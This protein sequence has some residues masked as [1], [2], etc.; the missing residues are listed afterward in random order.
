MVNTP[1]LIAHYMFRR[2]A[3][4]PAGDGIAR[5]INGYLENVPNV[6][7]KPHPRFTIDHA[8]CAR[9]ARDGAP[10]YGSHIFINRTLSCIGDD[11]VGCAFDFLIDVH[12]EYFAISLRAYPLVTEVAQK[13]G[14]ELSGPHLDVLRIIDDLYLKQHTGRLEEEFGS[15]NDAEERKHFDSRRTDSDIDAVFVRF[16][17]AFFEEKGFVS[18]IEHFSGVDGIG[19]AATFKG[20]VLRDQPLEVQKQSYHQKLDHGALD[21]NVISSE[22]QVSV[23]NDPDSRHRV[24][25]F[26]EINAGAYLARKPHARAA[27]WLAK[28]VN[29]RAIF[30]SRMLGFRL[31]S[32]WIE[33][34]RGGG[35]VLCQMLD[36]LALYGSAMGNRDAGGIEYGSKEVRYF[37]IYAGPSRN[38]L[39]RLIRRIHLCGENR[40]QGGLEYDR[41]RDADADIQALQTEIQSCGSKVNAAQREEFLERFAEISNCVPI[42]LGKRI[43]QSLYYRE[44]L[45]ERM[46]ELRVRSYEGWQPYTEFISRYVAP[47]FS[48]IE[49]VKSAYDELEKSIR[50]VIAQSLIG[51]LRDLAIDRDLQEKREKAF[52][53]KVNRLQVVGAVLAP[54]IAGATIQQIYPEVAPILGLPFSTGDAILVAIGVTIAGGV[55]ALG[56]MERDRVRPE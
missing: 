39:G 55:C 44:N 45:A 17:E 8:K 43:E 54:L 31:G 9:D 11:S 7:G 18:P 23:S 50:R 21:T 41:I 38:Q 37:V 14:H 53:R 56:L 16:W 33:D 13:N 26:D 19:H 42:G 20:F 48:S 47:Q 25:F 12:S 35:A 28:F 6:D 4:H 30:F 36:G 2:A 10:H 46:R 5:L 1:A 52:D 29:R 49:A 40:I 27:V 34:Y 24:Q 32:D 3:A 22:T 15:L 51:E